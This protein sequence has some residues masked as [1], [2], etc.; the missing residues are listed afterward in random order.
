MPKR[1]DASV[2]VPAM[3]IVAILLAFFCAS[4]RSEI[5]VSEQHQDYILKASRVGDLREQ[6]MKALKVREEGSA[7]RTHGLT[8]SNLNVHYELQPLNDGRCAI[9]DVLVSLTFKTSLARWQPTEVPSD[10]LRVRVEAMQNNISEHAGQHRE[11]SSRAAQEIDQE[12]QSLP[13]GADCKSVGRVAERII[14]RRLE[15]LRA[16][17]FRYDQFSELKNQRTTL[18]TKP[19][20]ADADESPARGLNRRGTKTS[21]SV[22]NTMGR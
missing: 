10:E 18:A 4:A 1:S 13:K 20:D 3:Q 7:S 6:W 21:I 9:S 8:R 12:L 2:F 15:R 5:S 16:E 22:L 17:Q 14:S 11:N 19:M